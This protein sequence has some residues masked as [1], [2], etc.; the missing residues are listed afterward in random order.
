MVSKFYGRR[1]LFG[2]AR[3]KQCKISFGVISEQLF[4]SQ[5]SHRKRREIDRKVLDPDSRERQLEL[6]VRQKIEYL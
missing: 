1:L 4:N 5:V 3:Q 2:P 6:R